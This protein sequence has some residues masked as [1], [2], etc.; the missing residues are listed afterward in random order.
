MV[1]AMNAK[2]PRARWGGKTAAGEYIEGI[3]EN[4]ACEGVSPPGTIKRRLWLVV[5]SGDQHGVVRGHD[6]Q[7]REKKPD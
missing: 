1:I 6:C 4:T 3:C 7:L 5:K 2:A